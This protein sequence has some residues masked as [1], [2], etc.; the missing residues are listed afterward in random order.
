MGDDGAALGA[1]PVAQYLL[2]EGKGE[3]PGGFESW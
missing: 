2:R 3:S 1:A